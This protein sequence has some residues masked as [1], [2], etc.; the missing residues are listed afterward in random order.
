MAAS[1]TI[2][3]GEYQLVKEHFS[4]ATLPVDYYLLQYDGAPINTS[5]ERTHDSSTTA[6]FTAVFGSFWQLLPSKLC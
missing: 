5:I 3:K 6:M 4:I 1:I 2:K